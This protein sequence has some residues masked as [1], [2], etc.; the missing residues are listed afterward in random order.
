V[1]ALFFFALV[2][3]IVS[4]LTAATRAQIVS[5]RARAKATGELY[6]FSRKVAAIGTLDDLLWATA[7]QVSSMLKVSTVL[8]LPDEESRAVTLASASPPEDTLDDADMA[9]ARWCWEHSHPTGRGSDTL[10]GGKWLFLPL[11]TG[12]GTVGVLGID[13]SAPAPLFTPDERR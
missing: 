10:P 7:F 13:R 4:N 6:A 2:A 1:V 3:V 5:A 12:S 11:R 9:A 8:L